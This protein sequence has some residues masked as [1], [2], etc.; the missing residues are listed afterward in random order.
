MIFKSSFKYAKALKEKFLL[1]LFYKKL[2]S[3]FRDVHR[4]VDVPKKG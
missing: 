1:G 2:E 3:F 4:N